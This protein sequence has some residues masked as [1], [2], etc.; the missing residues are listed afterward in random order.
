VNNL[1]VSQFENE[2]SYSI[3]SGPIKCKAFIYCFG[4]FQLHTLYGIMCRLVSSGRASLDNQLIC[5]E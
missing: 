4:L 2:G 1:L 5:L 3:S